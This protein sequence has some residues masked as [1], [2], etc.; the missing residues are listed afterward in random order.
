MIDNDG[1]KADDESI[2]E[3]VSGYSIQEVENAVYGA[4]TY[5]MWKNNLDS[6]YSYNPTREY[7]EDL[8]FNVW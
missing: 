5:A 3:Y 1:H 8:F 7:L 6:L 4:Y 2:P